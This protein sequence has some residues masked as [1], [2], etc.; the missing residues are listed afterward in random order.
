MFS[1]PLTITSSGRCSSLFFSRLVHRRAEPRRSGQ[2]PGVWELLSPG[3]AAQL[4]GTQ[5][6]DLP[7]AGIGGVGGKRFQALLLGGIE[8]H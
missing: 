6:S 1:L 8:G 4:L 5:T 7:E 3:T 2:P